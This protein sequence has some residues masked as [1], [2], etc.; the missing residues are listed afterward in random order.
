MISAPPGHQGAESSSMEVAQ[1]EVE[2]H[3]LLV[4]VEADQ[5]TSMRR[6]P[7]HPENKAST[8]QYSTRAKGH[9]G[10]N[11]THK[12]DMTELCTETET[13]TQKHNVTATCTETKMQIN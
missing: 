4:I 13:M 11:M 12:H 8:V 7:C 1:V 2:M 6:T 5:P 9:R 10:W 3:R